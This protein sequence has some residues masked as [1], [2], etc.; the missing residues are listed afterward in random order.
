M[1]KSD[2]LIKGLQIA[3]GVFMA[4]MLIV[5]VVLMIK[6]NITPANA[7]ELSSYFR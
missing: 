6:Y 2:K 1:N 3:S 7:K 5:M 4:V